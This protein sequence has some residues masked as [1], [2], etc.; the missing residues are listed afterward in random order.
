[1]LRLWAILQK[2]KDGIGTL[3]TKPAYSFGGR[4]YPHYGVLSVTVTFPVTDDTPAPSGNISFRG[5]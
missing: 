1:M 2:S 4:D 3:Q 5:D